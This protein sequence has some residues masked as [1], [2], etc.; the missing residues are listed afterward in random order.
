MKHL[1]T[2]LLLCLTALPAL[3]QTAASD[4]VEVVYFHG[5]QRCPT[6][7]AIEKQ[8]RE[9][10]EKDLQAARKQGRLA[11]RIVDIGTAEGKRLAR[12]YRVTW[13]ALY[14]TGRKGGREK[15]RDLTKFAF[16]NARNH[17]ETF[18]KGLKAEVEKLL[19]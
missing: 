16:K 13:S 15:R 2:M 11:L 19:K 6:C 14:V 3:A 5:K 12:D 18:R 9:A 1:L 10:V 7:L 8:T 17:P 4:R